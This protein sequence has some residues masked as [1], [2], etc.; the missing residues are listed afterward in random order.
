MRE[1]DFN[2][3]VTLI[4]VVFLITFGVILARL[5]DLQIRQGEHFRLLA[6]YNA[7]QTKSIPAERGVFLD[8]YGEPL[9]QNSVW[10][11]LNE[12]ALQLFGEEKLIS[13][14]ELVAQLATNAAQLNPHY[15]RWYPFGAATAHMLGYVAPISKAEL[16]TRP[17]LALS[18][19]VGKVGLEKSYDALLQG[20]GGS[21][22][23]QVDA[24]GK[25]VRQEWRQES[26]PG[27]LI[28]TSI[29]PYLSVV[30]LEA[31]GEA[32]GAI[33][34]MDSETGAV[35]SLVSTPSFDPNLFA[36][37]AANPS[38]EQARQVALKA[39]LADPNQ[40]FFNRA[41]GAEYPPGSVFKL[42]TALAALETGSL[43]EKTTVVDEGVLKVGEYSY[44]NWFYTQ[45]G[46]VD[47]EISLRRALARSNDIF[48]YK[49]AEWTGAY[50]L[51]NW[52]RNLGFGARPPFEVAGNATGLIPDP[53]WKAGERGERWFLGNT[54]H[55]GIGQGD[56][57]VTPLQMAQLVQLIANRG[58]F[59]PAHLTEQAPQ[60]CSSVGLTE[61]HLALVLAGMHDAC[62]VG[63]TGY[64]FFDHNRAWQA[65]TD[66]YERLKAGSIACK[67]GTAE[68]GGVDERGFR[69]THGW[70][71]MS[72]P[73][74]K[75]GEG[76][77]EGESELHQAWRAR[78]KEHGFPRNL[79]VVVIVESDDAHPYREG[80]RD[81]APLAKQLA[82]FVL[83]P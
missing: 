67:T 66:A 77:G 24:L 4:I 2:F 3:R 20:R 1:S 57:L 63:G 83:A 76:D 68:F 54:Y 56:T 81:A 17:E 13:G 15:Q 71:V 41:L 50:Q 26:E 47:G 7:I 42:V 5:F 61:E 38:A 74:P 23:Y 70:F 6:N 69:R 34:I 39:E 25:I 62:S 80:S 16:A 8:R 58:V 78:A 75:V 19:R 14:S 48:F 9:V 51:A 35:L 27:A 10:Y 40:R 31:L 43:D 32:R 82:D 33:L 29:D 44:A 49:T 64:V 72:L 37:Q 46:G 21:V 73:V 60:Q 65:E 53:A 36:S 11:T 59:C 18:D 45:Y 12:D 79:T 52:A 28:A 22:R 30:A 55:F